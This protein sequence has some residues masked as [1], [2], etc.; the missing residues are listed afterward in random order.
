NENV[1]IVLSLDHVFKR[2]EPTFDADEA[3]NLVKSEVIKIHTHEQEIIRDTGQI[4]IVEKKTV[5][6]S[7][8]DVL[9]KDMGIFYIPIWCVEG[10]H[11]VMILNAGNGKIIS[12][13][14]YMI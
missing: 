12:E 4:T 6:P 5:S 2:L 8:E 9:I 11:G 13:D 3:R 10:I 7:P 1:D 14:Y